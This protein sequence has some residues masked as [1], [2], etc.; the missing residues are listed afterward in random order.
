MVWLVLKCVLLPSP[1][2]PLVQSTPPP[3]AQTLNWC[4]SWLWSGTN[5]AY[6]RHSHSKE[7]TRCLSTGHV[8]LV[9]L[10][11]WSGDRYQVTAD[12]PY[13]LHLFVLLQG[14]LLS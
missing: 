5:M 14:G 11:C 3:A 12:R 13:S 6:S 10:T 9:L 7:G 4:R 8:K 2:Q 1:L